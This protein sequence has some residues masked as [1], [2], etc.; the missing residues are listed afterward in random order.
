M[1]LSGPLIIFPLLVLTIS[2][3]L[4][5][6]GTLETTGNNTPFCIG[7]SASLTCNSTTSGNTQGETYTCVS[8]VAHL[9]LE[10]AGLS[11]Q[12]PYNCPSPLPSGTFCGAGNLWVLPQG[13]SLFIAS[14]S[15]SSLG[16]P[17]S[18]GSTL[19]FGAIGADGFIIMV[20]IS[21]AVVAIGALNFFG[22]GENA[23]GIH[24]AWLLSM[25]LGLWGILSAAEGVLV[26]SQTSYFVQ[27]DAWVPGFGTL[28][29]IFLSL[30]Y[31][32]GCIGAVSRSGG[33]SSSG[34]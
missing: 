5:G 23:E 11:C 6:A 18:V 25:L 29:Y 21:V 16:P 31:T 28:A 24:I 30:L 27:L 33:G 4:A 26:Q 17:V 7:A 12:L 1:A 15:V 22:S 34:V 32:L 8:G 2:I 14:S 9:H 13:S 10:A 19:V 3:L 20:T